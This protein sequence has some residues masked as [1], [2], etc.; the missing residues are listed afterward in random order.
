[1][2][3]EIRRMPTDIKHPRVRRS[4]GSM[5]RNATVSMAV[6]LAGFAILHIIAAV[7]LQRMSASRPIDDIK[8]TVR[9]D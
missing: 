5:S 1:L 4:T 6:V 2:Q 8:W 9:G 7:A 3:K